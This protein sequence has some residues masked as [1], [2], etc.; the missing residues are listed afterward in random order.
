MSK[1]GISLFTTRM[2]VTQTIKIVFI[3][4]LFTMTGW[5]QVNISAALAFD[6]YGKDINWGPSA[7]FNFGLNYKFQT[8]VVAGLVFQDNT[9]NQKVNTPGG[10][11]LIATKA[12][13]FVFTLS[14]PITNNFYTFS[15]RP[16]IGFG[17]KFFK[18]SAYTFQLGALGNKT[19][20]GAKEGYYMAS[21]ALNFSKNVY[22]QAALFIRP[23]FGFYDFSNLR[24]VY[25]IA[26]GINVRLY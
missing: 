4:F 23:Q 2:S 5:A 7:G 19:I 17:R 3:Y 9:I 8:G 11:D 18:R 22:K 26:G 24:R 1:D 14:Y 13:D 16:V 6:Q 10:T 20:A 12:K 25:T 21:M 15:I